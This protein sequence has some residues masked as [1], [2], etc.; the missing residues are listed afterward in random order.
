MQSEAVAIKGLT[1]SEAMNT[2]FID[3]CFHD[4]VTVL[5]VSCHGAASRF[6][7]VTHSEADT[8]LVFASHRD[9]GSCLALHCDLPLI[10]PSKLRW[11]YVGLNQ[12][13]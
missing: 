1:F 13:L 5:S 9:L 3:S 6:A 11:L 4:S 8:N 12:R 10:S 7:V 2:W